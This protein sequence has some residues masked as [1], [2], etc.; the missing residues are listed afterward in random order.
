MAGKRF[1]AKTNFLNML[2]DFLSPNLWTQPNLRRKKII[3][4]YCVFLKI[5]QVLKNLC[6]ARKKI[7]LKMARKIQGKKYI[8]NFLKNFQ[9][10]N[11]GL[12]QIRKNCTCN[13][14]VFLKFLQVLK[15]VCQGRN[16][17]YLEMA[18]KRFQAK[19]IF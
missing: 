14:F 6:Q 12:S 5:L 17:F 10:P 11:F 19:Q 18:R 13:I 7:Y 2:E 1:Q 15:N 4:I 9:V 8:L 3:V 16:F